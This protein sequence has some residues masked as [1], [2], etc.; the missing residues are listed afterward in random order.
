MFVTAAVAGSIHAGLDLRTTSLVTLIACVVV[1]GG[2]VL[3]NTVEHPNS[4]EQ[5]IL[6][7][8]QNNQ[9]GTT[10][11]PLLPLLPLLTP[12][13]LHFF[14]SRAARV[15]CYPYDDKNYHL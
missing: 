8:L 12:L 3:V 14:S 2:V 13:F 11:L 1:L 6:T 15:T 5:Q 9:R 10:L 4:L 7:I